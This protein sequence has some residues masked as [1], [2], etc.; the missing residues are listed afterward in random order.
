LRLKLKSQ[1]APNA[2]QVCS[3]TCRMRCSIRSSVSMLKVRTVPWISQASG[4]TL[5]A[6]PAW[7]MVTLITPGSMG[8][9]L[10][11]MMVW[12]AI[13]IWQATG[14]GSMP[15]CGSAAWLPLPVMVM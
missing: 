7:I 15:R 8:L 3:A 9:R 13:T 12:K 1:L 14:T 11:V 4:T 5:V 10:R 6:S 2:A